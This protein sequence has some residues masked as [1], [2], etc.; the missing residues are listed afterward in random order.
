M[1][2]VSRKASNVFEQRLVFTQ[3]KWLKKQTGWQR[4]LQRFE[5]GS[6]TSYVA[7]WHPRTALVSI[8]VVD[9]QD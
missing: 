5:F 7:L 9:R 1:S 6:T 2:N 4:H 8:R 3:A